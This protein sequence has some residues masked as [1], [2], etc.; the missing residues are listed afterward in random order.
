MDLNLRYLWHVD[1]NFS[2]LQCECDKVTHA[3][4]RDFLTKKAP[5]Q[6]PILT[7]TWKKAGF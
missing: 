2:A 7:S 5:N 1:R 3:K 4:K 6:Q